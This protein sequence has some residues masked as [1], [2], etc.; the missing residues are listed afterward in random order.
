MSPL[1]NSSIAIIFL[2]CGIA[3]TFIMLELR[4]APKDRSINATLIKLHKIFGWIFMG[5][6]LLL[7]IVMIIKVSGYKEEISSRISFHIVLSLALIPLLGIKIIIA[8]R[9]PRLSQYLI[10]FGPIAL[11]FAVALTGLTAGYYFMHSSDIKYV[12]LTGSDSKILDENLGRQ[13]VNQRCNKCHTL[14]RVY[15]AV[16]SEEGWTSTINRMASLDAP[17]ISSFDIKQSIHFLANRQKMLKGKDESQLNK[18]FGKT[19]METKCTSCHSL[20]RIVQ[21]KKG[22]EKWESTVKRMIKYSGNPEYLTKKAK[23]ELIEYLI[24]K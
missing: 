14:E 12:S 6:F 20:E 7:L 15:R 22:K 3:A 8:R 17:N 21:A 11:A 18:A 10:A 5:I 9:Y 4:G 24:N 13:V 2:I 19:I 23:G 1:F 16:K